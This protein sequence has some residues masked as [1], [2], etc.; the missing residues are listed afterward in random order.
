M[1]KLLIKL[2][3]SS[4]NKSNSANKAKILLS[5]ANLIFLLANSKFLDILRLDDCTAN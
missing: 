4:L 5:N 2:F 1:V 3:S